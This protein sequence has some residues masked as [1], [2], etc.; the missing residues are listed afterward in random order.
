MNVR[1][2]LIK[3]TIKGASGWGPVDLAYDD[4]LTIKP[5]EISYERKPAEESDENPHVKWSY[6]TNSAYFQNM[7][8]ILGDQVSEFEKLE[9]EVVV[10]DINPNQVK[11]FF[12]DE[13]LTFTTYFYDG[14]EHFVD[15]VKLMV[16]GTEDIPYCLPSA[17][18]D[19]V[20][21][22]D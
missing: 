2:N 1:G 19:D 9:D 20:D 12:E 5:D 15:M 16:P 6:K 11:F 13:V 21:D 14:V 3:I 4:K 22:E 17:E 7:F 8:G 18:D 10:T